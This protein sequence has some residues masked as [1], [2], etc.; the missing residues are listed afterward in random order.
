MVFKRL[1]FRSIPFII[2]TLIFGAAAQS[3]G[4]RMEFAMTTWDLGAL[5]EGTVVN[6][7]FE[8][9]NTGTEELIITDI[10]TTCGS[11]TSVAINSKRIL[12]GKKGEVTVTFDSKN[13]AGDIWRKVYLITNNKEE[14]TST[15]FIKANVN[16]G[17][18]PTIEL[19]PKLQDVG[20]IL[21][22]KEAV[23][24][25][26][27]SNQGAGELEITKIFADDENSY[28]KLGLRINNKDLDLPLKIGKGQEKEVEVIFIPNK[29]SGEY[30]LNVCFYNNSLRPNYYL[31]I[32][33]TV[34]TREN[35]LDLFTKYRAELGIG[36]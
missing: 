21:E 3:G 28:K 5:Q 19:T 30:Y 12:P 15:L 23:C 9:K 36:K 27:I 13:L 22:G 2:W 33:A 6:H 10:Q 31:N 7:V 34:I 16:P 20:F 4:P 11:C 18:K 17:L 8:F 35:L 25:I 26:K 14:P 29:N 1:I 24:K 32:K